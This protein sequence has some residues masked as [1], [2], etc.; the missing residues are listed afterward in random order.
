MRCRGVVPR[1][2]DRAARDDVILR[3]SNASATT[4]LKRFLPLEWHFPAMVVDE[5]EGQR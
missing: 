3:Q 4:C 2:R 5:I 1:L